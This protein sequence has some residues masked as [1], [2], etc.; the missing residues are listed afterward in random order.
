METYIP[1]FF[2]DILCI[3]CDDFLKELVPGKD[4]L[5]SA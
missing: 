2:N 5:H 4:F 3:P 1:R